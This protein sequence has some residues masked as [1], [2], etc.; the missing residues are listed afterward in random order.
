[1]SD[2]ES[3]FPMII[4]LL[5]NSNLEQISEIFDK[6]LEHKNNNF[7]FPF[8]NVQISLEMIK[9][10]NGLIPIIEIDNDEKNLNSLNSVLERLNI[11]NNENDNNSISKL[12]LSKILSFKKNKFNSSLLNFEWQI[13]VIDRKND[14][15]NL[16]KSEKIEILTKF[17][18]FDLKEQKYKTDLVKLN[19]NEFEEILNNFKKIDE[20]LHLFK[21]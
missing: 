14:N 16:N 21:Q 9:F 8:Y 10:L 5:N 19:Y 15:V 17:N 4:Q 18:H 2:Y 6:Y 7:N 20:Q 13:G 1:M 12:L 11:K 3:Q